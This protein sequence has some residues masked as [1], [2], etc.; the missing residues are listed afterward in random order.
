MISFLNM[1]LWKYNLMQSGLNIYSQKI[2]NILACRI[3]WFLSILARTLRISLN[4]FK[5][6][7]S[8]D[9]TILFIFSQFFLF[10]FCLEMWQNFQS[11]L[12]G[13]NLT[14]TQFFGGKCLEGT[15]REREWQTWPTVP[16]PGTNSC[17]A[18]CSRDMLYVKSS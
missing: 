8:F 15:L 14:F 18:F 6:K 5:R 4:L 11:L 16:R 13:K 7:W 12:I 10:L 1:H 2:L 3:T 17:T 9:E